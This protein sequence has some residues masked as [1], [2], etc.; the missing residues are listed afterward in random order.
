M[1]EDNK[2]NMEKIK[3]ISEIQDIEN[4]AR[5][6]INM[7]RLEADKKI[8]ETFENSL[9]KIMLAKTDMENTKKVYLDKLTKELDLKTQD[10]LKEAKEKA[11][12]IKQIK[13]SKNETEKLIK[14]IID[15]LI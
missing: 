4:K 10:I 13:L 7:A 11:T 12:K 5:D 3:S 1:D 15:D 14:K 9:K 6:S 8:K 2:D